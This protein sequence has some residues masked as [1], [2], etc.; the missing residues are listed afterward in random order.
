MVVG[1]KEVIDFLLYFFTWDG[2]IIEIHFCSF[3]AGGDQALLIGWCV[4]AKGFLPCFYRVWI[5]NKL[6]CTKGGHPSW[7]IELSKKAFPRH[8]LDGCTSYQP[9]VWHDKVALFTL[10]LGHA[11]GG[12]AA[13]DD[14]LL[15]VVCH[16]EVTVIYHF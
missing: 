13:G 12:V 9:L 11:A 10:R 2:V 14:R 5:R 15:V 7:T 16:F 6:S 8:G 1:S 4:L 3:V